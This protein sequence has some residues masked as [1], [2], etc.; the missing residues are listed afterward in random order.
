M[1]KGGGKAKGASFERQISKDLSLWVSNGKNQDVFWRSA[2]SGGRTTV[3]MKKGNKLSAQA[4]DLSSVHR[5]GHTFID[6]FVVECKAYKTLN[7]ESI[8]KGKGFLL[9]FWEKVRKEAKDHDKL[10]MLVGKQNNHPIIV[11]L[12]G[13]GVKRLA[14]TGSVK[15]R[16][17][18]HNLNIILWDDFL[19]R[20][21]RVLDI[22]RK[23]VRLWD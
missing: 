5:L 20:D 21:P 14:L 1:R 11:C 18:D 15:V 8:I 13:E 12:C 4:G 3:A 22:T 19:K 10:P 6:I 17:I 16:V 2:M 7:F 23:R 9:D